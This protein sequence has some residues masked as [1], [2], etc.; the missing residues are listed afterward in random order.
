MVFGS[1]IFGIY[2]LPGA[3]NWRYLREKGERRAFS[4]ERE[5]REAARDR[6]LSILF[7]PIHSSKDPDEKKVAETLG[8][9]D[10]LQTK[11]QDIKD[12]RKL[13]RSGKR[14]VVVVKGRV[15]G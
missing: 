14:T 5:A 13:H 1:Q 15:N 2:K 4:T 8:V 7:P 3:A 6:A 9:E 11:R 10:W 12:A